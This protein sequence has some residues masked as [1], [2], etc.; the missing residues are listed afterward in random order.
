MVQPEPLGKVSMFKVKKFASTLEEAQPKF[1][2]YLTYIG[3][4]C[5]FFSN[6]HWIAFIGGLSMFTGLALRSVREAVGEPLKDEI[7]GYID[8]KYGKHL[9]E[10]GIVRIGLFVD[11]DEPKKLTL[12]RKCFFSGEITSEDMKVFF[13]SVS[14][15]GRE[16]LQKGLRL[17][18]LDG[19][20][21]YINIF[22][23]EDKIRVL[24][25]KQ[26]LKKFTDWQLKKYI[27]NVVLSALSKPKDKSILTY[28]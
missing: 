19:P 7:D 9:R 5:F 10:A 25:S 13:G 3:F 1:H 28:P 11:T 21:P 24:G 2:L 17:D 18:K 15:V 22:I 8:S 14:T 23:E 16:G 6:I 27:D 12:A 20:L 4:V 26:V